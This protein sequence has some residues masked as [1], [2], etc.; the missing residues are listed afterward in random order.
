MLKGKDLKAE[1]NAFTQNES[2]DSFYIL[3]KHYFNYLHYLGLKKGIAV[4]RVKDCIN[5]LFLYLWENREKLQNTLNHHNY[6]VTA[7]LRRL[8]RNESFDR[9]ESLS[10]DD[11]SAQFG[12]TPSPET[13][14]I[15]NT[16]T[17]EVNRVLKQYVD[18]LPDRQ[19]SM[20]YQKF[21]LGLSYG[22]IA[23][24]NSVSINTVYNTIYNGV[25][26]LRQL[27]G[28]EGLTILLIALSS[29]LIIFLFFFK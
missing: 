7:F 14:H 19:R 21:Y 5:D 27:I 2:E 26:K 10:F 3:Y 20:I 6:I 28:K 29:A 23:E 8:Y 1:W 22:E 16:T 4:A 25:D 12:I 13:E 15:I 18:Q 24:T 11:D 9:E 17:N